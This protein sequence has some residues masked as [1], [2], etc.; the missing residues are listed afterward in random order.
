MAGLQREKSKS[1]VHGESWHGPG[2]GYCRD[3]W[4]RN[5]LFTGICGGPVAIFGGEFIA[6][7]T[8]VQYR[9]QG[10]P[11]KVRVV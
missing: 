1:F 6:D 2:C 3:P 5:R 10:V 8:K 7:G 4:P 9:A 11:P